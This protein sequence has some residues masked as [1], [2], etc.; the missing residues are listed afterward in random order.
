MDVN[1][2]A[3]PIAWRGRTPIGR[4]QFE[5]DIAAAMRTIAPGAPLLNLCR[6]RYRFAVAFMAICH[7][8]GTNVLPPNEAPEVIDQLSR[9]AAGVID[10][11]VSELLGEKDR[12][13]AVLGRIEPQHPAAIVHTSGTTG[14]PRSLVKTWHMLQSAAEASLPAIF[15]ERCHVVATVPPQH[16]YGFEHGVMNALMGYAS[17][18]RGRP[19]FPVDVAGALEQLPPPRALVTTPFHLRSLIAADVVLP[20]LS[21]VI[22]ATAPLGADTARVIEA[23]WCCEVHEV[24]GLSEA[25]SIATRRP[26]LDLLWR[27][28]PGLRVTADDSGAR[29]SAPYLAQDE[30]LPDLIR[31]DPDGR[32]ELLGR[33]ADLVKVGGKRA[34]LTHLN[35]CLRAIPGVE[36]GV[37]FTPGTPEG[38]RP[39]A[40]VVAPGL[41]TGQILA[42]L[43]RHVDPVFL[44]RPLRLVPRL[45]RNAVGK[46]PREELLRLLGTREPSRG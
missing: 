23:R 12:R 33:H 44:P 11:R 28:F 16:M 31:V 17:I 18:H 15:P 41:S 8:G 3:W 26:S 20:A 37:I 36:D 29:V 30:P 46:L 24:Y 2:G 34:S 25:G 32:F 6:D 40:L 38:G 9:E 43:A 35:E 4:D 1:R 42:M 39:A 22:S 10:D 19:F 7:R 5:A 21:R 13:G 14:S 27:A 45:P